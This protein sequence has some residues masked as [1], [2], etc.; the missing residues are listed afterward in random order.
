MET[1]KEAKDFLRRNWTAGAK[2]PCCQQNVKL[3]KRPLGSAQ[4]A[5][6]IVTWKLHK[7]GKIWVHV[8]DDIIVGAKINIKG[9]F[10]KCR[11]WGL[12]RSLENEDPTKKDS[13]WWQLT[14]KGIDFVKNQKRVYS[15]IY[16]YNQ[17]FYGFEKSKTISIL[18][19]LK[20]KFDYSKLIETY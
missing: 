8:Q 18:D 6:L 12:I 3:Y 7:K 11:F 20:N 2:C 9:D 17:T 15:H 16:T 19:A 14:Q 10:A 5:A 13:G 4:A 1:I